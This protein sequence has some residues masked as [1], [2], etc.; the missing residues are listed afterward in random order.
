M[1]DKER[2]TNHIKNIELKTVLYKIIDKAIGIL[3][4]HDERYTDFLNP[5]ELKNAVSVLNGI[6][7][8]KYSIYGG[9]KNCERNLIYIYP[10]YVDE[11][12]LDIPIKALEVRGN[13]KFKEVSHRD[14]LGSILGLGIKREKIGDILIHENFCQI[15]VQRDICDFIL[16]NFKKVGNN[17]VS[18]NE[19]DILNLK[20][21]ASQ[22]KE[23]SFT[24]SSLRLDCIISGIYNLSRQDSNKY[25]LGEKVYVD[26]EPV[27]S[28]SKNI[29]NGNLISIR[30]KGRAVIS[31][32][33]DLTKKGRIKV[34]A[35]IIL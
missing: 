27:N 7:D 18:I 24:A 28:I 2:L 34:K 17:N 20:D 14:Y 12:D 4:N 26:F 1:I 23:I 8:V 10:Y 33:G 29:T 25:I 15:V 11:R 30:G 22:H 6:D 3:K 16:L 21:S 13:F 9:Y 31:E 5:Y 32:I 35:K 19:I